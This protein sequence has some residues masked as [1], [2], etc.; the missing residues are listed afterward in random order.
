M[1]YHRWT[2][3]SSNQLI[4]CNFKKGAP[5]LIASVSFSYRGF[6]RRQQADTH[7]YYPEEESFHSEYARMKTQ[8]GEQITN[9]YLTTPS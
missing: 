5:P 3:Q 2:C 4:I 6:F 7:S 1:T 8:Q 9:C